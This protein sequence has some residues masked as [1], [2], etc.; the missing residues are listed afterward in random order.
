MGQT[1]RQMPG[2]LFHASA[3][4]SSFIFLRSFFDL[5]LLSDVYRNFAFGPL[6][7][8]TLA[9]VY[10]ICMTPFKGDKEEHW[11]GVCNNPSRWSHSHS[12]RQCLLAAET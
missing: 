2:S 12:R 6:I 11:V 8:V 7:K 3:L 4:F 5:F 10:A 9:E 1:R